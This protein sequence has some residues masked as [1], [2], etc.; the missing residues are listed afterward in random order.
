MTDQVS[1]VFQQDVV[2][3]VVEDIVRCDDV[4][5]KIGCDGI[6]AAGAGIVFN[7][8]LKEVPFNMRIRAVQVQSVVRSPHESIMPDL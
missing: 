1:P 3:V 4:G 2:V 6:S 8:I 7:E 5:L